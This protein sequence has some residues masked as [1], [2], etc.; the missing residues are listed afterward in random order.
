MKRRLVMINVAFFALVANFAPAVAAATNAAWQW[1]AEQR[2]KSRSDPASIEARKRTHVQKAA[3]SGPDAES[4]A[5]KLVYVVD[6]SD[7]PELMLPTELWRFLIVSAFDSTNAEAAGAWRATYRNRSANLAL[8]NDFWDRVAVHVAVYRRA[9][10][11]FADALQRFDRVAAER[12]QREQC[13]ALARTLRD[14]RAD[15]GDEVFLRFLYQSVAPGLVIS[16]YKP[17]DPANLLH[18]EEGCP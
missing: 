7:T 2:I 9:E 15:L 6:G 4:N 12:A 10:D 14:A 13:R 18:Q 8:S 16:D 1:T 11:E 3:R 17:E 5:V